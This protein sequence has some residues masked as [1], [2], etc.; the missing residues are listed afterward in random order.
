MSGA[1]LNRIRL[2]S[3]EKELPPPSRRWIR[4]TS[5]VAGAVVILVA[6]ILAFRSCSEADSSGADTAPAAADA[7]PRPTGQTAAATVS[8]GGYIEARRTAILSPGR[9][10]VIEEI[11]VEPGQ[12]VQ[13]GDVLLHIE[14][15]TERAAVAAAVAALERSKARLELVIEGPRAEEIESAGADVRAAAADLESARQNL[16][17]I[18][19]LAA[20]GSVA[21]AD[22]EDARFR[23]RSL[24]EKLA[25]LQAREKQLR[26]GSR[27]AEV[28]EARAEMLQAEALLAQARATL[29]LSTMRAPFDG[30]VV[31]VD[32]EVGETVSLFGGLTRQDGVVLAD[33]SELWV[34]VDV[35]EARI[36][37]VRLGGRAEVIVDA[38]AGSRLD[39]EVV[40][41]A[42]VADRQ[43]NTIEVAV[44][45][46]H[47]PPLL[48][49]DMSARVSISAQPEVDK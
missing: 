24:A 7:A 48:R 17:R 40:E 15:G 8:A 18:E 30:V 2:E 36:G 11:L 13:K 4:V 6:L 10:G 27:E 37:G 20:G 34:R 26:A 39:A 5:A 49:P 44:R 31:R 16:R 19:D 47:P 29:D 42:P 25:S 32:L 14:A 45:I 12:V 28:A 21:P 33:V 22:L 41:I 23:E 46:M 43:S 3:H 9:T 35:P 1:D 38:V